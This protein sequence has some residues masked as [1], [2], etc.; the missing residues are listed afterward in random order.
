MPSACALD[1]LRY[2]VVSKFRAPQNYNNF[3]KSMHACT[4]FCT[5]QCIF[6]FVRVSQNA[7]PLPYFLYKGTK[8]LPHYQPFSPF[9]SAVLLRHTDKPLYFLLSLRGYGWCHSLSNQVPRTFPHL[10]RSMFRVTVP[11]N[12]TPPTLLL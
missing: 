9:I 5:S 10:I 4:I 3:S 6:Q 8:N 1:R 7:T 11:A 12:Q 2:P